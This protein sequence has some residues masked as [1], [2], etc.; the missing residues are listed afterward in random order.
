MMRRQVADSNEPDFAVIHES[1]HHWF[2]D[3][4]CEIGP[5]ELV[6]IDMICAKSRRFPVAE[7]D[8]GQANSVGQFS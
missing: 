1:L 6:E 8:F 7:S 5:M 2:T 3:R 4:N